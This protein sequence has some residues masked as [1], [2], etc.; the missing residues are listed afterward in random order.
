M[1]FGFSVFCSFML[2]ELASVPS[3]FTPLFNTNLLRSSSQIWNARDDALF[4]AP[5][6]ACYS[7]GI[8][9]KAV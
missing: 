7:L 1:N 9:T 6:L 8:W 3:D 4:L 2:S 5:Q